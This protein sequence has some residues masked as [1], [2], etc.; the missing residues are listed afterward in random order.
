MAKYLHLQALLVGTIASCEEDAGDVLMMPYIT[1]SHLFPRASEIIHQGSSG[2]T[3][4]ALRAGWPMLVV[5][6]GWDQ[7][8]NAYR[9][10][11]LGAGLHLPRNKYTVE[12]ATA[13][14]KLLLDNPQFSATSA[15]LASRMRDEDAIGSACDAIGSLLMRN[16][17]PV[18]AASVGLPETDRAGIPYI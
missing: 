15:E 4:D 13:A 3:G 16:T 17:R 11:R 8:D 5:P 18:R 10:N 1:Y 2:T 9:I 7:P 12:T 14:I 6:Y